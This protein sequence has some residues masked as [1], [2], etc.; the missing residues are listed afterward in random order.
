MNT[1]VQELDADGNRTGCL[2]ATREVLQFFQAQKDMYR[3]AEFRMEVDRR[4]QKV[5]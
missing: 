5:D 3:E 2:F 4:G 1:H